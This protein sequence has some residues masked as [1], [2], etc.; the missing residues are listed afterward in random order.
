MNSDLLTTISE[1]LQQAT[2]FSVLE[3]K[4]EKM[5][6]EQHVAAIEDC[7]VERRTRE[8]AEIEQSRRKVDQLGQLLEETLRGM[9]IESAREGEKVN[10]LR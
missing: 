10:V 5:E 7:L 2:K 3:K 1:K 9:S 8:E 4:R 6:A